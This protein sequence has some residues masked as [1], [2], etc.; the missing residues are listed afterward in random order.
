MVWWLGQHGFA[1]RTRRALLYL[2]PFLTPLEGR[3][4]PPMLAPSQLAGATAVFGSHDHADHIDRP[5]WPAIAAADPALRFVIPQ[6]LIPRVAAGTGIPVTRFV[7]I[8][9]RVAAEVGGVRFTGVAAAHEFLDRDP[10]TGLHPYL[11]AVIEVDGV[12]LFHS[13][14]CCVYE[15]LHATL[16]AWRFDAMLLPINGRCARRLA[17]GCIG[18]MTY[19][20]AADLAGA[21]APGVTVPAHWDMFAHNSEDP[22]R[23]TE[24]MRVKYPRLR[25][26]RPRHGERFEVAAVGAVAAGRG[27]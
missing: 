16:R 17:A 6:L 18:N 26:H 25:V 7:G 24:Y 11:G 5:A 19:Q 23:F 1:V 12:T 22:A 27:A 21:M 9:D 13:G 10:A 3:E 8:D 14:D 15:G 2:D 20:E 4:V